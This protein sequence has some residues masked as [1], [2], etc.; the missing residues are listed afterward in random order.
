MIAWNGTIIKNHLSTAVRNYVHK[1]KYPSFPK[2]TKMLSNFNKRKPLECV[3]NTFS[4]NIMDVQ[5]RNRIDAS[6][7]MP[8]LPTIEPKPIYL[9]NK[10]PMLAM[11]KDDLVSDDMSFAQ[12]NE[13]L[14]MEHEVKL[15]TFLQDIGIIA[16]QHV[17]EFCGGTMRMAKQGNIWYWICY[18][19]VNGVKCNRGKFGIR[20]G[21]FLDHT[22]LSIQNVT[23]IIW[24]FVY[25]LNIDQCKQFC[26]IS[27]KTDHTVGEYYADC[28]QVCN[29]WIWNDKKHT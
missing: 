11:Y 1:P 3:T 8:Q 27:N 10:H 29:S 18:R 22:H 6:M 13:M 15:M 2:T 28:R 9:Q 25:G 7:L 16:K 21:T 19:R 12:L 4:S 23:R 26:C 24:N 5:K 20:K 14:D 17:C